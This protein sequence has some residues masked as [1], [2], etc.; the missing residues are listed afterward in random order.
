MRTEPRIELLETLAATVLAAVA[1]EYPHHQSHL[2]ESDD[3][4]VP[5]RR[6]H[7]MFYGSFDWHSAVHGHWTLVRLLRLH[8]N[9]RS[10]SAARAHLSSHWRAALIP[11]KR[12]LAPSRR[13]AP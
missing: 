13:R 9:G 12:A 5:P 11:T 4:A 2:L 3:D 6:L 10:A 8:P 7:P 1:R